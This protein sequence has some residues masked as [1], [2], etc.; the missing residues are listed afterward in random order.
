MSESSGA[1]SWNDNVIAEFRAGNERIAN[2]FDRSSLL[3]LHTT[4]ARS[5]AARTSPL[6]YFTFD[7]EI[8]IVASAAGAD[9]HPAW[10]HNLLADPEATIERWQ[11][12]AIESVPVKAAPAEGAERDRLWERITAQAKGFAGYQT[13]TDRLIPVVVL[14]RISA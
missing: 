8:V 12:G 5:G 13:K 1:G 6:A 10:Y 11:D 3:L 2:M 14:H 7:D 4:G 9:K